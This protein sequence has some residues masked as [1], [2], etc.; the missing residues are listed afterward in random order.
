MFIRLANVSESNDASGIND[1][2]ET[3]DCIANIYRAIGDNQK[4][5]L[6][7]EQCLKRRVRT[8]NAAL[9]DI[10][11]FTLLVRTYEDVITLTKSQ[12]KAHKNNN[13]QWEK[14]GTLFVEV[15]KLYDLHLNKQMKALTCFHSALQIFKEGNFY[16]QIE[17][18][19]S[20]I[21]AVHVKK[22]AH[23]K[24]L[25]CFN[26]SLV[27][28]RTHSQ[29]NETTE[30]ADTLHNIGNCEASLGHFENSLLSFKEALRIKK[31]IYTAVHL[32]I[33]KTEHCTGLVMS[34]LGN[35]G[36]ALMLFQSSLSIRK[37]LL[38]CDHLDVSFSLHRLVIALV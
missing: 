18:T 30:I 5:L 37:A 32:S 1:V 15:G 24:A 11:Q 34:Q 20:L 19:L 7:F 27:I 33:A 2:C 36:D 17:N 31:K 8:A 21:G 14:L 22:S 26:D 9:P 4:A 38:G 3:L 13:D 35:L 10:D 29:T 25:K 23:Q 6:F 28:Q 12:A 16:K